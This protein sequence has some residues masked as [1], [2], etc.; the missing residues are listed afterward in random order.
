MNIPEAAIG[1]IIASVIGATMVLISTILSKEQKTSEFRQAWVDAL[2]DDLS[3]FV[4]GVYELVVYAHEKYKKGATTASEFLDANFETLERL[5]RLQ[6]RV[7]LR[8]NPKEHKKL[9]TLVNEF[10]DNTASEIKS[11][12]TTDDP[13]KA[14]KNKI[15]EESQ[16]ILK[17]EWKR[18]KK[19]EIAFRIVKYASATGVVV[20]LSAL[21]LYFYNNPDVSPLLRLRGTNG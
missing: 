21:A 8:L 3:E 7:L 1:A 17:M 18:V 6:V 13:G 16:R 10:L 4:G 15:V 11:G 5:E 19:G 9:I 14:A 20:G 12:T 2:R